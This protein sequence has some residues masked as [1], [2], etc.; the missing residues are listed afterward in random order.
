MIAI[1]TLI[2]N[3]GPF[4]TNYWPANLLVV[5]AIAAIG[6]LVIAF[7][8]LMAGKDKI[9]NTRQIGRLM[10]HLGLIILLFGVFMSEN[11]V[12]ETNAGYR[13]GDVTEIGPDIFIQV[14]DI[15]LQY[16]NHDRDFNMIDIVRVVP[17]CH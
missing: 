1:V 12:Y 14:A 4:P 5:P 3:V 10:L 15:N 2:G 9:A 17:V 16:F 13:E 7:V 6:F 8:R 11:V